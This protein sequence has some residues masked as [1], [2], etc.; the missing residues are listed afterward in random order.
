VIMVTDHGHQPQQGF[1][2]GFQSP[3]ETS[4]FVIADGPDFAD[5]Q[6]NLGYQIV[7][8]TPTVLSLFGG[9][10]TVGG[11]GVPLTS[12]GSSQVDPADLHQALEDLIDKNGWPDPVT[13]VALGLRTIFASIP[14]FIDGFVTD[15]TAQLQSIAN[16]GIVVIS[17]LASLAI[18]PVQFVGDSVVGVT[19]LIAQIVAQLTGVNEFP[20]ASPTQPVGPPQLSIAV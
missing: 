10:S 8:V 4:T 17:P 13:T 9:Q 12:L 15:A 11:D 1:G 20:P 7:D 2:H 6:I 3:R 5:G 14:Y 19:T 16:Q 18:V